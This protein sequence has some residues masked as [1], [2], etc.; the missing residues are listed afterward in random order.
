MGKRKFTFPSLFILIDMTLGYLTSNTYVSNVKVLEWPQVVLQGKHKESV[1]SRTL[2]S[3]V[4]GRHCDSHP[5]GAIRL[6][7]VA[8]VQAFAREAQADDAA[9][10]QV[11]SQ[12]HQMLEVHV[13]TGSMGE[14]HSGVRVSHRDRVTQGCVQVL[15][16][17]R[18]LHCILLKET[19]PL[20]SSSDTWLQDGNTRVY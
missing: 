8:Q 3:V 16:R 5:H 11:A 18:H 19:N 15:R 7:S 13:S 17:E 4:T 9:W 20:K 6:H 2:D 12:R 1:T 10:S 14:D